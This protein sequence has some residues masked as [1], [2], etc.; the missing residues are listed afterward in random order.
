MGKLFEPIFLAKRQ[1][2]DLLELLNSQ[3][4]LPESLED[5]RLQL[6]ELEDK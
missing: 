1:R 3:K 5:I 2:I 4:E 6:I